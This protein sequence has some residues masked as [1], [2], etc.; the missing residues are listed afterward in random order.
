MVGPLPAVQEPH[1]WDLCAAHALRITAPRGWDLVR[2]PDI[3]TSGEDSDLTAL[4]DAVTGAPVGERRSGAALVDA[5]R[6]RRL[7]VSD[8]GQVL[9]AAAGGAAAEQGRP[10]LR[11]VPDAPASHPQE[12]GH[13]DDGPDGSAPIND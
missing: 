11:V 2:H 13:L 5:D 10:H 12:P 8:P 3:D 7:G 6:L 1:A 4:L 9:T